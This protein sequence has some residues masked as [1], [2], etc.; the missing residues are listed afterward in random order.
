MHASE[1]R[2]NLL[3]PTQSNTNFYNSYFETLGFLEYIDFHRFHCFPALQSLTGDLKHN[4]M[5][6]RAP[7]L[8]A[9]VVLA[10]TVDG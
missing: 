10:N 5:A 8:I 2:V 4:I 3:V 6:F 1:M 7:S 9:R